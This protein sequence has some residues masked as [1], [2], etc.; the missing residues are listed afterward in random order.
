MIINMY[1][2]QLEEN[3]YSDIEELRNYENVYKQK[4]EVGNNNLQSLYIV[5]EK[6]AEKENINILNL[7]IDK[8]TALI[9][10]Y[11][12]QIYKINKNIALLEEL[13]EKSSYL[14][15]GIIRQTINMYNMEYQD[16][17][18]DFNSNIWSNEDSTIIDDMETNEEYNNQME[19]TIEIKNIENY[20]I[21]NNDTLLISEILNKV[22]LPYTAEEV[23]KELENEDNYYS[24]V[25]DVIESE[26]TKPLSYYKNQFFARYK[27]TIKLATEREGYKKTD[28]IIL[29][30]EMM[31]KRYLYPAVITACRNI[32]EL[33]VYIDCLDKNELDDFKIFK[34]KYELYPTVV[35]NDNELYTKSSFIKRIIDLIKRFF[36]RKAEK[37]Q[38]LYDR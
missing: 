23:I 32:D 11:N 29:A 9:K 5:L 2:G 16:I 20:A 4:I 38:K 21:E 26:F 17:K 14:N 24:T 37:K 1:K 13:L 36:R 19:D 7:L 6:E 15:E 10:E 28:A 8:T 30:L 22:V 31:K 3:I 33:D 34:I 25:Y 18:K 35:K 12:N 27:E